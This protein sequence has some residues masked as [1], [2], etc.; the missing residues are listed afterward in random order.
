MEGLAVYTASSILRA[1]DS[2]AHEYGQLLTHA[3]YQNACLDSPTTQCMP[4]VDAEQV[5]NVV[6][7]LFNMATISLR[8]D[9]KSTFHRCPKVHNVK[10]SI[11]TSNQP[12][13]ADSSNMPGR[14]TVHIE[15]ASIKMRVSHETGDKVPK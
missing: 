4:N 11:D 15:V 13:G 10:V 5:S 6:S 2:L 3:A 1:P 7:N 12:Y 9:S 14:I 8:H